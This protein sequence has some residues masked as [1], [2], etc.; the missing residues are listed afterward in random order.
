[1]SKGAA[2]ESLFEY[3]AIQKGFIVSKPTMDVSYDRIIDHKGKLFRVQIKMTSKKDGNLWW[4]QTSKGKRV[5]YGDSID[6]IAIYIKPECA[7]VIMPSK[8]ITGTAMQ[9]TLNGK[10]KQYVNNW[11]LFYEKD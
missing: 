8:K 9:F 11:N 1:M 6:V 5:M 4:V 10:I 3:L 2:A 7:W